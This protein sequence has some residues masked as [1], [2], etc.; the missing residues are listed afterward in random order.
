MLISNEINQ[1]LLLKNQRVQK[2]KQPGIPAFIFN[3]TTL[4][5]GSNSVEYFETNNNKRNEKVSL[6]SDL[7]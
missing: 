3:E 5:S 4:V 6:A 1:Q 2:L 7:L